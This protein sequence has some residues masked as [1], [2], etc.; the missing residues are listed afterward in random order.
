MRVI[1]RKPVGE[2]ALYRHIITVLA[3]AIGSYAWLVAP[4]LLA[5]A[6]IRIIARVKPSDQELNEQLELLSRHRDWQCIPSS[7]AMDEVET[8][9]KVIKRYYPDSNIYT[10]PS[11]EYAGCEGEGTQ[12]IHVSTRW[13][14]ISDIKKIIKKIQNARSFRLNDYSKNQFAYIRNSFHWF[15][16]I[17]FG[18]GVIT[19]ILSYPLYVW[20][21]TFLRP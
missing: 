12:E 14:A 19:A 3:V 10:K 5:Y 15:M 13:N 20:R 17:A 4:S 18:I 8:L 21:R 2:I 7:K 1:L 16:A 11:S 9:R 6:E